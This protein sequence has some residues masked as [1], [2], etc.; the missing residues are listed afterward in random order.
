MSVRFFSISMIMILN[1]CCK[2]KY[3]SIP[4]TYRVDGDK[5]LPP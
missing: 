1:I 3:Y 2:L 4:A 5:L